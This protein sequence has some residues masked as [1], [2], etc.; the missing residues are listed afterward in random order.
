MLFS[1]NRAKLRILKMKA[2]LPTLLQAFLNLLSLLA[3]IMQLNFAFYN[4]EVSYMCNR[5]AIMKINRQL[6]T[7]SM[8][9]VHG[10]SCRLHNQYTH[11]H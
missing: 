11:N 6:F 10:R 5:Q 7:P 2:W 1:V 9:S 4:T 3:A 8:P